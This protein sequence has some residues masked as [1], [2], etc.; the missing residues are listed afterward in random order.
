MIAAAPTQ[1]QAQQSERLTAPRD[2]VWGAMLASLAIAGAWLLFPDALVP[3]AAAILLWGALAVVFRPFL[4]CLVFVAF[5]YFRLHEAFPA[6]HPLHIPQLAGI[7]AMFAFVLHFFVIQSVSLNWTRELKLFV[8]FFALVSAGTLVAVIPEVATA[9]WPGFAK[10][11]I[12]T[13]AIAWLV[14]TVDDLA[15]VNR[16]FVVCG[17]IIAGVA[18]YNSVNGIELVGSGRATIGRELKSPIGDP[19][20]LA[21]VLLLPLSFAFAQLVHRSNTTNTLLAALAVPAMIGAI[22]ATQSRG[23]LIG[24]CVVTLAIGSQVVRSK[25]LLWSG[26]CVLALA[27]YFA[28]GIGQRNDIGEMRGG[29]DESSYGRLYGWSAATKMA[30]KRPLTGVGLDNFVGAYNDYRAGFDKADHAIHSSWFAVLAE[31]GFPGL[32]IFIAMIAT[33]FKSIWRS[34]AMLAAGP[35][36]PILRA[37]ALSLGAGLAGVCAAGTFLHQ[38][39]TWPLYIIIALTTGLASVAALGPPRGARLLE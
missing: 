29:V 12:M 26:C 25:F 9:F 10:I 20:D 28:M 22:I 37:T 5:S 32:I 39:F 2:Q 35:F 31:I 36:D 27:L 17:L 7:G 3:I 30:L 24:L 23:G 19:N 11:A 33:S 34:R 16:L 6:L 18:I 8:V 1:A 14:R 4:T 13:F 21:F 15:L 38:A